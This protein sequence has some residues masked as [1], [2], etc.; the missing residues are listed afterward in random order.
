MKKKFKVRMNCICFDDVV[1]LA[2]NKKEAREIAEKHAQCPQGD[3][4][5]CEFLDVED[6]E[7][8]DYENY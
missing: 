6:S 5:F 8:V 7:G 2:E 4:E 3:M 1:V